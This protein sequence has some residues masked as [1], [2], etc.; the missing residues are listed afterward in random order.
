M[1]V[2]QT[3]YAESILVSFRR[4]ARAIE[5]F[6]RDLEN[7]FDL[8]VSQLLCMRQLLTDGPQPPSELARRIY[9]SQATVTGILNRL[10]NRSLIKRERI[11][12]DRRVV[13]ISLT[14][15]GRKLVEAAPLPLQKHFYD[16]LNQL[17]EKKQSQITKILAQV[18]EMMESQDIVNG[19]ATPPNGTSV[20]N[21]R[22]T[23]SPA[24]GRKNPARIQRSRRTTGGD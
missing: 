24:G 12:P 17:P 19:E 4:I 9:L 7:R 6:S 5:L 15:H 18:V 11:G 8:T 23:E 2:T 20:D 13:T 21:Q 10:E 1:P 16:R 14:D 22:I 3:P